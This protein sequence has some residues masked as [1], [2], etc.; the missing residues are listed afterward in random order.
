MYSFLMIES[1]RANLGWLEIGALHN[2]YNLNYNNWFL[3][4]YACNLRERN[5]DVRN[6]IALSWHVIETDFIIAERL[7]PRETRLIWIKRTARA[8]IPDAT[9]VSIT[10]L[11]AHLSM[12][13]QFYFTCFHA[14][15]FLH[16]C[17]NWF[18]FMVISIHTRVQWHI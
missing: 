9:C 2:N 6:K 1:T 16:M 12:L 17:C 15:I 8:K 11:F 18:D 13:C 14:I 5:Q 7:W 4:M 3:F 10:Y